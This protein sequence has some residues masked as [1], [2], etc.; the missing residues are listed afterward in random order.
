LGR[1]CETSRAR[2]HLKARKKNSIAI[3]QAKRAREAN[4][5]AKRK[6]LRGE[7]RYGFIK[8]SAGLD[9]L[10]DNAGVRKLLRCIV[11]Q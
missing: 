11:A 8:A 2:G 4:R 9:E 3:E 5:E 10:T 1:N 7:K 6:G